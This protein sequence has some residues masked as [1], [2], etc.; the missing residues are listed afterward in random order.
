MSTPLEDFYVLILRTREY[1]TLHGKKDFTN[2]NKIKDLEMAP[3]KPSRV[4]LDYLGEPN[5]SP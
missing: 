1:V 5:L 2:V 3:L 4:I